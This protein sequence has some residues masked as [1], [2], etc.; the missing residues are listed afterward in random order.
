MQTLCLGSKSIC[1]RDCRAI[2][3][4]PRASSFVTQSGVDGHHVADTTRASFPRLT[5]FM[6]REVVDIP[7]LEQRPI[8]SE[9]EVRGCRETPDSLGKYQ[10][11]QP[12]TK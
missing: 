10:S 11:P 7:A 9:V 4:C 12:V 5:G 1:D 3:A 6:L 2:E 8:R